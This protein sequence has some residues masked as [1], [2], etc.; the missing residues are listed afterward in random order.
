MGPE[1]LRRFLHSYHAHPA[2]TAHEL[3]IVLNGAGAASAGGAAPAGDV[4]VGDGSSKDALLAELEGTHHRLIELDSPVLDL[5]A[6]GFA[7]RALE[8]PR[9]C[10]L[11]SHSVILAN[12]WLG[13]LSRGLEEPDV[14][15]VGATASWESQSE[16]V[17]GRPL[18]WAY[19]LAGLRAA[20]RDYP[21]FPNPHIRTTGFMARRD[22]LLDLDLQAARDKRATYLLESGHRSITRTTLERGQ[23][24]LVV[25]RDGRGYDV[26][27]WHASHTFRS[28]AQ[29]NLLIADNRTR[30]WQ[31]APPRL[32]RRLSRDAWGKP[33]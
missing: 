28:G 14:G 29:E 19:Q 27:E 26:D 16:W 31:D 18:Y 21:R 33:A 22:A 6:Y 8:H 7:A 11:N 3:A 2:G 30:D 32:R 9:L 17:R 25:G 1:P 24:T 23:R 4:T 13:L 5:P 10:F 20:R 12:G 15:L